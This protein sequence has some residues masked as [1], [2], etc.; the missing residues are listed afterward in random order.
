MLELL[1]KEGA[2]DVTREQVNYTPYKSSANDFCGHLGET[3]GTG[4]LGT[5]IFDWR[6]RAWKDAR[7]NSV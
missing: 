4:W 2:G 5:A 3:F 1:R 7:S 6:V